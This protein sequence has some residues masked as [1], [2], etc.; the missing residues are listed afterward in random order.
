MVEDL[1]GA[2]D[3]EYIRKGMSE[4]SVNLFIYLST[5]LTILTDVGLG[6]RTNPG[7]YTNLATN[8]FMGRYRSSIFIPLSTF[9]PFDIKSHQ[10]AEIRSRHGLIL[11]CS[12]QLTNTRITSTTFELL[13]QW[14]RSFRDKRYGFLHDTGQG[15]DASG[16]LPHLLRCE[17]NRP[18]LDV[19]AWLEDAVQCNF[20][21]FG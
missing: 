20:D 9:F 14:A 15:T 17:R 5:D 4:L 11:D 18:I 2:R 19:K 12:L 13:N 6:I 21:G 1:G 7:I 8:F 10:T 16:G 3:I